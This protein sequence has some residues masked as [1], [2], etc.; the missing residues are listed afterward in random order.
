LFVKRCHA[1]RNRKLGLGPVPLPKSVE[2]E[3]VTPENENAGASL[4]A[5]AEKGAQTGA[6]AGAEVLFSV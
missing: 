4:R 1:K 5:L 6:Q 3:F 2:N